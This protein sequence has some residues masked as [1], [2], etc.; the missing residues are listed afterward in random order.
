MNE[1]YLDII[2]KIKPSEISDFFIKV[3]KEEKVEVL[4]NRLND[5]EDLRVL[6]SSKISNI[7]KDS[8]KSNNDSWDGGW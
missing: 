7:V 4:F 2:N 8:M 5:K 3:L 6:F 1:L